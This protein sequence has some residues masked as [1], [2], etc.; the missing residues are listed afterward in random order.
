MS[1]N[2][3]AVRP[4]QTPVEMTSRGV[5]L[6]NLDEMGRFCLAVSKSRLAP[7][8]FET[9]EAIMVAVQFG[10]EIGLSPM[11]SLQSICLI[12]GR[13]S[14]WGDAALALAMG[15]PDFEDITEV[16]EGD[17]EQAKAICTVRR[18]G[19]SPVTRVFSV[20]DA[21][22]A[23]LWGKSGPWSQYPKR[24]LQM[25]ARSWALR[26]SFPDALKGIGI[27]EE[28][29]DIQPRPEKPARAQIILPGDE[30]PTLPAAETPEHI[31]APIADIDP[32]TGEFEWKGGVK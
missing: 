24:M 11:Q 28:V 19:R 32:E 22:K 9:P 2:Q 3:L 15:R 25:R 1:E 12:N 17:G 26:D 16:T 14:V 27:A 21:K 7:K 29:R 4:Q 30:T 13:P 6:S 8:G 5:Q 23:G 18:A 20:G 10:L 31:G